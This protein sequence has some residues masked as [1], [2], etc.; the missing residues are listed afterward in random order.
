MDLADVNAFI[1]RNGFGKEQV[2]ARLREESERVVVVDYPE[3]G[4]HPDDFDLIVSRMFDLAP[5]V[6]FTTHSLELLEMM[7]RFKTDKSFACWSFDDVHKPFDGIHGFRKLERETLIGL[8][9]AGTDPRKLHHY[10]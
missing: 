8:I 4:I 3:S 10:K 1:G 7:A 6:I 5:G 2:A 9:E